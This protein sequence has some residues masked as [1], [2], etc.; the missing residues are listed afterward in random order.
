MGSGFGAAY[1]MR[2]EPLQQDKADLQKEKSE[3]QLRLDK[4]E[5]SFKAALK[6]QF[7]NQLRASTL[8][9]NAENAVQ[10]LE[11]CKG[12]LGQSQTV[13]AQYARSYTMASHL[14]ELRKQQS[15]TEA[16][17]RGYGSMVM[18]RVPVG[19]EKASFERE[20]VNLQEQIRTATKCQ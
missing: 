1:K 9:G 6:N 12:Q 11:Q 10:T 3:L 14:A 4:S 19:E 13:V 15:S 5:E 8:Q 2:I 7:E 16:A 20:V 17:L 18:G